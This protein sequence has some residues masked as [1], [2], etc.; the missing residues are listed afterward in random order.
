MLPS[1]SCRQPKDEVSITQHS[2]LPAVVYLLLAPAGERQ[3]IKRWHKARW[4]SCP[5][6]LLD[7][8]AVRQTGPQVIPGVFVLSLSSPCSHSSSLSQ[9]FP[10]SCV[11][12]GTNS[13]APSQWQ[14][15]H[16]NTRCIHCIYFGC[17]EGNGHLP[18]CNTP[19]RYKTAATGLDDLTVFFQP[20]RVYKRR[21]NLPHMHRKHGMNQWTETAMREI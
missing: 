9:H 8:L 10:R 17:K 6:S 11:S 14:R 19:H 2:G 15:F 5:P 16:S 21:I 7:V 20:Y 1:S 3:S 12:E 13:R 4:S 18:T